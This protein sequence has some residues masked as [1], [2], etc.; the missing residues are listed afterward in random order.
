MKSYRIG[1][2][3]WRIDLEDWF[4]KDYFSTLRH[5]VKIYPI[6]KAVTTLWSRI[7][8]TNARVD[9]MSGISMFDKEVLSTIGGFDRTR[10]GVDQEYHLRFNYCD[11][12]F[13][14]IP[15]TKY[16]ATFSES[17]LT[18]IYP[19][20]GKERLNYFES[21]REAL[22]KG[23]IFVVE[24]RSTDYCLLKS[25]SDFDGQCSFLAFEKVPVDFIWKKGICYFK[26][27]KMRQV[28][29]M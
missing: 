25:S 15:V 3:F 4:T 14:V 5:A 19:E 13:A 28:F 12:S 8:G 18:S 20:G 21:V 24:I 26:I 2:I 6:H 23:D 27:F 1:L 11:W 22:R 9:F 29:S 7:Q 17:G 16:F 10:F